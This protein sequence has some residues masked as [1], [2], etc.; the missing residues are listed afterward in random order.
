MKFSDLGVPRLLGVHFGVRSKTTPPW[1]RDAPD[2]M[3]GEE[4]GFL[5]AKHEI[6]EVFAGHWHHREA[7]EAKGEARVW[8]VGSLCPT[9]FDDT[10]EGHGIAI[11]E[12]GV[13]L[14]EE[15][16]GPRFLATTDEA[17][18][19]KAVKAKGKHTSLHVSWVVP[20]K[21]VATALA[22]LEGYGDQMAAFEVVPN[23]EGTETAAR[24]AAEAARSATALD[25]A[26]AAFVGG[27]QLAEGVDR[28][29]VLARSRRYLEGPGV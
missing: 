19:L 29:D 24:D 15:I 20:S 1:L 6:A 2:S 9:G 28:D 21:M 8:Q 12:D 14:F 23:E 3:Y 5:A 7:R 26:L 4:L 13:V 18:I 16:E 11:W 25:E 10:T 27:M 22:R 17:E